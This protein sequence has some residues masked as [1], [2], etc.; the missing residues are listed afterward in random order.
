MINDEEHEKLKRIIKETD[1][2]I[3]E[4]AKEILYASKHIIKNIEERENY[5]TRGYDG[6]LKPKDEYSP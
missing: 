1:R 3:S 2:K 4:T 5:K 6:W